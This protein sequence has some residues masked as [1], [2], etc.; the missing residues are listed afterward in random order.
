[1]IVGAVAKHDDLRGQTVSFEA[2]LLLQ[3]QKSMLQR[4]FS[5]NALV[6]K[7]INELSH[8]TLRRFNGEIKIAKALWNSLRKVAV[9]LSLS[10]S[11][12]ASADEMEVSSFCDHWEDLR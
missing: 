6:F 11:S 2:E 12:A 10:H 1:M 9:A 7:S 5:L 8:L 4:T 3:R